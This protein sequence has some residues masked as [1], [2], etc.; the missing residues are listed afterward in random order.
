MDE[1]SRGSGEKE[2]AKA[3]SSARPLARVAPAL[4]AWARS[5]AVSRGDLRRDAIAGVPGAVGSVPDGMAASVF[6]G[7]NPIHGLYASFA[8]PIFGGLT[9]ST[10]SHD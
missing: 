5:L 4:K 3:A 8:G 1:G 9:S 6:I 7:V 2:D 10:R